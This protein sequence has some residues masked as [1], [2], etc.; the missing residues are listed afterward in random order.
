MQNRLL[1][2]SYLAALILLSLVAFAA[3]SAMRFTMD[4][5]DCKSD[6]YRDNQFLA[7]CR[8]G[9]F[10]D[11]EH[12]AFYF[13]LEPGLRANVARAQVLFLGN[14]RTQAGFSSS[15]TDR[16][17]SAQGVAYFLLGFGYGEW[18]EF[19]EAV[20]RRSLAKPKILVINADPFFSKRKSIPATQ[21]LESRSGVLWPS[22][23][24]AAF[25]YLQPIA[26]SVV[27]CPD[28]EPSFFRSRRTGAWDWIGHYVENKSV[29]ID[30]STRVPLP[31][32][33]FA[34]AVA[35]GNRFLDEVGVDRDCV[36]LTGLPNDAVDAP[37]IAAALAEQ[38]KT[39]LI[40]L[41]ADDLRTIEGGHLNRESAELWSSRF[42]NILSPLL[43]ECL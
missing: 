18:S 26:C 7:Y 9:Q 37:A 30:A 38:L 34:D 27:R 43:K 24:K 16:Y 28:T 6:G 8:S 1:Q 39:R 41:P 33:E 42:L 3:A 23:L 20:M 22:L 17:F 10:A 25:Q 40:V 12:A 29:P 21:M 14:S 11:Y 2:S 15:A 5:I 4:N 35:I 19:E 32:A 36:V 31:A 13:G